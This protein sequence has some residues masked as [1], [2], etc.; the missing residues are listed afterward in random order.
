MTNLE[1]IG[2]RWLENF[3]KKDLHGLIGLYAEESI[4]AQ[5]YLPEPLK[6]K[7]AIEEDFGGFLN[8]FPDGRMEAIRTVAQGDTMA[9]EWSFTGTHTGPLAGPAGTI[10]P[11][12]KRVTLKG[13]EFT[14]HNSQGLIVEERGYF[15]LVSF[16]SQLGVMPQPTATH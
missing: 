13:A 7:K 14:R 4:N 2:K 3:N 5:P 8:A 16:M 11:T 15:D 9:M 1:E 12:G 6:G 10:Q